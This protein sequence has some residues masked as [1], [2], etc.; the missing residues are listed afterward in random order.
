MEPSGAIPLRYKWYKNGVEVPS[1]GEKI[2]YKNDVTR[3][4]TGI[5]YCVISNECDSIRT[6]NVEVYYDPTAVNEVAEINGFTLESPQPNPIVNSSLIRFVVPMEAQVTI[7]LRNTLGQV[8]ATLINARYS[9]GDYSVEFNPSNSNLPAG[10][11]FTELN[12][13]NVR[14]VRSTVIIR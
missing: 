3:A 14:I 13:G 12:S 4:D 11:Y 9:A 8:V 10:V 2:F 5:Y 1:S 7:S 6:D